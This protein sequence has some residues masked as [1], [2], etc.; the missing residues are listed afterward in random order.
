MIKEGIMPKKFVC[1]M[2]DDEL[3]YYYNVKKLTIK[4]LCNV[5]GCKS[6]ITMAKVLH[7]RGFDTNANKRLAYKK[8]GNRTDEEFK[9]LLE[10]EYVIKRRSMSSIADELGISNIVIKRY[11]DKYNIP[12]RTKSE[13]QSGELSATWRGGKRITSHGYVELYMPNH[14]RANKRG[15][16]YEHLYVAEQILNRELKPNEVVHH[17]NRNK[18]DNRRENLLILDRADHT[19]LHAL[20]GDMHLRRR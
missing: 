17:K 16:I 14:P 5:V 2:S 3:D 19:R 9:E 8:R 4:E 13:Q 18:S 15:C 12:Q 6:D 1:T 20:E 10:L 11:L 7:D